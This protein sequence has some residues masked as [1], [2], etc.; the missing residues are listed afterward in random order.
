M[1]G[2]AANFITG[3]SKARKLAAGTL[4]GGSTLAGMGSAILDDEGPFPAIQEQMFGSRNALKATIKAGALNAISPQVENR[5]F[6]DYYYGQAVST[7]RRRSRTVP[8]E[9]VFGMYNMRRS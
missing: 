7:S 9:T 6:E 1:I 8:G 2:K 5:G 3:S 4:I